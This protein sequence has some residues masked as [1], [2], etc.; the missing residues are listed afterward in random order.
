ML[1]LLGEKAAAF[2]SEVIVR[3]IGH[4]RVLRAQKGNFRRDRIK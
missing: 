4:D 3:N 2:S 1:S